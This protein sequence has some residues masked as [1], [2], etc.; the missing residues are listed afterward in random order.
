[1]SDVPE[2]VGRAEEYCRRKGLLLA[3]RLGFGVHGSVFAATNQSNGRRSAVKAQERERFYL[4]ERNVYLRLME[5]AVTYIHGSA[6][7][8]L[9]GYD[10]ELWV[11]SVRR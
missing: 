8:E 7:P 3:N 2:I 11:I 9:L 5:N 4:R 10:D 1:M 6:V